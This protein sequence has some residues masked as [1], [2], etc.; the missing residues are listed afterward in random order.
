MYRARARTSM[1]VNCRLLEG[2]GTIFWPASVMAKLG[3]MILKELSRVYS[4]MTDAEPYKSRQKQ[5]N[6]CSTVG[7]YYTIHSEITLCIRASIPEEVNTIKE[8]NCLF[9]KFAACDS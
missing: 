4:N 7:K 1:E 9:S 5:S 3:D 2:L 6:L 8:R